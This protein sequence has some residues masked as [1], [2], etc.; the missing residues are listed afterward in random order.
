MKNIKLTFLC[1]FVSVNTLLSQINLVPNSSFENIINCNS[2]GQDY[3]VEIA[4]P[5]FNPTGG[6][7]DIYNACFKNVGVQV[8]YNGYNG[9]N[10]QPAKSGLGYV[11]LYTYRY[12]PGVMQDQKE[13]IEVELLQKLKK[14]KTY[15]VEFWVANNVNRYPDAKN[16]YSD[17]VGIALYEKKYTKADFFIIDD[18]KPVAE[19]NNG[20]IDNAPKWNKISG[21]CS[22]I[23]NEYA[24]LVIGNFKENSKMKYIDECMTY[25]SART[26]LFIDDVAIYECDPV[27]DTIYL[28][29][30]SSKKIGGKFLTSTYKWNTGVTDSVI[31]V[32]K[33]GR[34]IVNMNYENTII[35][36]T[37]YVINPDKDVANILSDTSVC[38]GDVVKINFPNVGIY[39][40]EDNHKGNFLQNA[41]AGLYAFT[42]TTPCGMSEKTIQIKEEECTCNIFIPTAFSPNGDGINDD[43]RYYQ[44]CY[45]DLKVTR[46][47]IFDRWGNHVF[48]AE[49]LINESI[50]WDGTFRGE[51]LEQGIYT[52]SLEYEYT[53]KGRL[54]KQI[55]N[56]DFILTR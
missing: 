30:G 52:Y 24:F 49:N 22:K 50:G 42:I 23:K 6:T 43:L 21:V 26:Y 12:N 37:T 20:I 10:Y 45:F 8:P 35:S 17:A 18:V 29:S 40:W 15:F 39:T 27:P 33:A 32:N 38:K 54:I 3:P 56:G 19:N 11:G 44:E 14:E 34:Y 48:L 46:F 16:C 41:K 55:K 9:L 7:P 5:W 51:L 1:L 36:D 25:T 47:Q 31:T 2:I 28:C 4:F 13:Y 53:K